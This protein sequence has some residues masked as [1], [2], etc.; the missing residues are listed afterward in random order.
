[1]AWRIVSEH[2]C[3]A[4]EEE[5]LAVVD[6]AMGPIWTT[7]SSHQLRIGGTHIK[8]LS[9]MAFIEDRMV[10]TVRLWPVIAGDAGPALLLG[11]LAIEPELQGKGVG[12]SLME[13]V[14]RRAHKTG[15]KAIIL[16]GDAPYYERFGFSAL[17]TWFLRMPGRYDQNRLLSYEL[18]KGYLQD[19]E[20]IITRI[21]IPDGPVAPL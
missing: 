16:V 13:E 6:H 7:R 1:M 17:P 18:E 8:D 15:H 5:L 2:E 21:A 3:P 12:K 9:L 10:G 4:N 14:L 11:P 19:K 20:G